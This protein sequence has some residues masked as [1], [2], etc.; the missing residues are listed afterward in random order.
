M[1]EQKI[2][3]VRLEGDAKYLRLLGGVPETKGMKS[4]Y[5]ILQPGESV[6]AH[7]TKDRE[8]AIII[9]E[10]SV[11]VFVEG[12]IQFTAQCDSVVYIP[13]QTNHDMKNSGACVARYV[14]V[15]A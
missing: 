7:S 10:G 6:G 4:G 8:E 1:G 9:L 2:K 3:V 5:V 12:V 15:V 14:Y 13:P 11:A